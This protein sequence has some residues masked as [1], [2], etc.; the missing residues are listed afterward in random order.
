MR[1]DNQSLH[2]G[3]IP[4]LNA[5]SHFSNAAEQ[6]DVPEPTI[7]E[8]TPIRPMSPYGVSKHLGEQYVELYQRLYHLNYSILRYGNVY[9]PR[10]DPHGEAG[11][12]AIFT[13]AML[14]ATISRPHSRS[15]L[16]TRLASTPNRLLRYGAPLTSQ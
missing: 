6:R 8:T 10:Q 11:V 15:R 9:G 16:S 7:A 12:I 13:Q 14:E 3:I 4:G 1:H 2:A 5:V